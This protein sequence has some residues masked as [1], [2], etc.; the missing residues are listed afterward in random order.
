MITTR[1][2]EIENK[3]PCVTGLVTTAAPN[4]KPK[5]ME[6]KI[7]LLIRLPRT[8]SIQKKQRFKNKIRDTIG[9]NTTLELNRLT[10]IK[11]NVRVNEATKS[12][13]MKQCRWILHLM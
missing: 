12:I 13:A 1:K 4:T 2:V 8:L 6:I 10:K 5:E 11:F 7:L 3:I 9:F